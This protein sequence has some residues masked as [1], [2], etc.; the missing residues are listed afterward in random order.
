MP[1]GR[2]LNMFLHSN[3][4]I[5]SR[6]HHFV[7]YEFLKQRLYFKIDTAA[8]HGQL[9]KRDMKIWMDG[10]GEYDLDMIMINQYDILQS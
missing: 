1:P 3:F 10:W 4:D 9:D 6:H 2:A 5:A 8:P 7:I